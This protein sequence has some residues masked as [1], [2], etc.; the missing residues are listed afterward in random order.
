MDKAAQ[1]LGIMRKAGKLEIGET[2][3]GAAV[4]A[5]KAKLLFLAQDASDNARRRAET[6]VYGRGTPLTRLPYP[7]EVISG[8]VGKS[9]CAMAA[10]TDLGLAAAF[11]S[12][13]A[14]EDP[15]AYGALAAR[16]NEQKEKADTRKQESAAHVRNV[17]I[18]KRRKIV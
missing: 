18:G 7:K 6:F 5:G 17:R 1:Y 15:E 12:A 3:A 14:G 10:V 2:D 8:R 9:G 13:L 16:L 4:K 11:A